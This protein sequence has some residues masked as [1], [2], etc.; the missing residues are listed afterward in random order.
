MWKW[1]LT[2]S[3]CEGDWVMGVRG[4][5]DAGWRGGQK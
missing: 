5:V 4:E 2:E 1:S 3:G